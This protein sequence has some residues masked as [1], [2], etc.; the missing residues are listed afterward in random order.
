MSLTHASGGFGRPPPGYTFHGEHDDR[1]PP[2]PTL[3][4]MSSLLNPE[5]QERNSH[6]NQDTARSYQ[7]PNSTPQQHPLWLAQMDPSAPVQH[8]YQPP[9][10]SNSYP[11]QGP[12]QN[13]TLMPLD[14][15]GYRSTGA[16]PLIPRR[17]VQ[18]ILQRRAD[19]PKE[20]EQELRTQPPIAP[21]YQ[22]S[23][24]SVSPNQSQFDYEMS[25][26]SRHASVSD[27]SR[28]MS[29]QTQSSRPMPVSGLLSGGPR[30]VNCVNL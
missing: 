18:Q 4:S 26:R 7:P 9:P 23:E 27:S 8:I 11:S 15:R 20:R 16:G 21:R 24:S 2:P 22:S 6:H 17:Q 29:T 10:P 3:P 28:R 1:R 14:Q 30:L 5:P 12:P 13:A 25:P 19:H